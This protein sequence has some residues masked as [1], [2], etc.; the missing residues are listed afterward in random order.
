[1]NATYVANNQFYVDGDLTEY[2]VSNRKV[3]MT[4]SSVDYIATVLSSTYPYSSSKTLVTIHETNCASGLTE[5]MWSVIYD[6][7]LAWHADI[8]SDTGN[9]PIDMTGYFKR[10]FL[11]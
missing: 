8:H 2:F 3:K 1:M 6:D 10:R 9:D 5:V 4:I 7:N 11:L